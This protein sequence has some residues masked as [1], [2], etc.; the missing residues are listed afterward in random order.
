[1]I[2]IKRH[3]R[4]KIDGSVFGCTDIQIFAED[5]PQILEWVSFLDVWTSEY[6]PRI[7]L[8]FSNITLAPD[9]KP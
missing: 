1:M 2:I 9:S 8:K 7:G 6:L 4:I 5:R 3:G